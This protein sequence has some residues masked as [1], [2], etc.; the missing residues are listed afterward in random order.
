MKL[1]WRIISR[2]QGAIHGSDRDSDLADELESHIEMQTEDNIRA[3]MAPDVARRA[4][5]LKF[6]GVEAIKES[7]RNQRGLP[8]I[9]SVVSDF[10]YAARQLRRTPAFTI[11]AV[12]AI[13]L[14]IG[15]NTAIFS[16][17]N[18]F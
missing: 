3:G 15:A 11:I 13:A 14:G 5:R 12:T 8:F 9:E 17:V 1:L 18:T 7:Y 4:A 10:R 6:G 16:V 2:L